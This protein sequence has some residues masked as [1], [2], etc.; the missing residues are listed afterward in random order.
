MDK[1][2]PQ[3]DPKL[4][5]AYDR[6]MGTTVNPAQQHQAAA[7]QQPSNPTPQASAPTSSLQKSIAPKKS[8]PK[9]LLIFLAIIVFFAI[10]GIVWVIMFDLKVPLLNP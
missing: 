8:R 10:Y 9:A 5:A 3:L 7:P 4:K 6:V 1:N 2:N